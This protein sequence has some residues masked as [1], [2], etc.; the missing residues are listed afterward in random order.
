M[1]RRALGHLLSCKDVSRLVSRG[2]DRSLTWWE[3]WRLRM[4]LAVCDGC[5]RFNAQMRLL[6]SAMRT[7]RE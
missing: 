1:I 2:H 3:G 6:W 7:Y 5:T 4:H